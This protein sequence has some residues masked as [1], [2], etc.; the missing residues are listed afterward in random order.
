[1]MVRGGNI[2]A[3][4]SMRLPTAANPHLFEATLQPEAA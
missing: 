3:H 4:R 1:M 2:A